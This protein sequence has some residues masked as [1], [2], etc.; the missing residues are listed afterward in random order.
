MDSKNPGPNL[1]KTGSFMK[2][3]SMGIQMLLTIL[4]FVLAGRWADKAIGW[5]IPVLTLV[6][7]L[8]GVAGSMYYFIRRL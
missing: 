3:S 5:R 8:A 6:L 1:K 4:I 2:Y 7:S